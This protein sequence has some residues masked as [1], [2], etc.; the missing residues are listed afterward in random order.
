MKTS[1]YFIEQ[2]SILNLQFI[3]EP[4]IRPNTLNWSLLFCCFIGPILFDKNG[5][6]F[7]MADSNPVRK[8]MTISTSYL[9]GEKKN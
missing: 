3:V 1:H 4:R 2:T 6:I 9:K 7:Q 5:E 8:M